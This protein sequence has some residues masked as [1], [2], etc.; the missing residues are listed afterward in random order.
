VKFRLRLPRPKRQK[1][2][3][4]PTRYSDTA[5]RLKFSHPL[6]SVRPV[7]RETISGTPTFRCPFARGFLALRPSTFRAG[8]AIQRLIL[9]VLYMSERA[10]LGLSA[11]QPSCCM[12]VANGL[13]YGQEYT[14]PHEAYVLWYGIYYIPKIIFKSVWKM[15]ATDSVASVSAP[16]KFVVLFIFFL[17][18]SVFERLQILSKGGR[19]PNLK[20]RVKNISGKKSSYCA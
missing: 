13:L 19:A 5:F 1:R 7:L 10:S 17:I 18:S 9:Y 11:R 6:A 14:D 16:N 12:L 15:M 20:S 2:D 3:N 4:R 8:F